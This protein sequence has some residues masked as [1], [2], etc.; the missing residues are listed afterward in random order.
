MAALVW[1]LITVP[2]FWSRTHHVS[3]C[4]PHCWLAIDN[5]YTQP[6]LLNVIVF[7]LARMWIIIVLWL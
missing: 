7:L 3:Y 6:L 5:Q 4:S 2:V 1:L